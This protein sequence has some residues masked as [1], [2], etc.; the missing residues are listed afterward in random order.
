M[1]PLNLKPLCC[2]RIVR[3]NGILVLPL[4]DSLLPI[5]TIQIGMG[6]IHRGHDEI[7]YSWWH[8]HGHYVGGASCMEEL[9][10]IHAKYI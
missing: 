6:S 10:G 8:V 3:D 7:M 9:L 4:F 1:I 2:G 5:G